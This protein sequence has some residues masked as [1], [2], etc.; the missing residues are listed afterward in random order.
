M[1]ALNG[2][3]R[4]TLLRLSVVDTS[5][6]RSNVADRLLRDGGRNI[7]IDTVAVHPGV[8]NYQATADIAGDASGNSY[9]A[10]L[11]LTERDDAWLII[12]THET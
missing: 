8:A 6:A 2:R 3:D 9:R 1:A 5:A 7:R 12:Y 10:R 11:E 4:D